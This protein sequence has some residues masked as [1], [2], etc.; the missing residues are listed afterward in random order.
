MNALVIGDSFSTN[1]A[2]PQMWHYILGTRLN[3][4]FYCRASGGAGYLARGGDPNNPNRFSRQMMWR[5]DIAAARNTFDLLIFFGSVNDRMYIPG[6]IELYRDAVFSTLLE[7]RHQYPNAKQLVISPQW[8]SSDPKPASLDA[9]AGIISDEM[10]NQNF[11]Y[12]LL[13]P[14]YG[15]DSTQW[16]FPP[17][18]SDLRAP[19]NFHPSQGGQT[20]LSYILEPHVRAI[21]GL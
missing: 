16:W 11:D 7:A 14:N 6:Q 20:H 10:W 17:N 8:C 12:Q 4:M 15:T 5:P 2:Q 9:M 1:G 13:Q 19:D 21:L 3:K 18:R